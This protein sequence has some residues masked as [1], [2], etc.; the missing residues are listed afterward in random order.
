MFTMGSLQHFN[1]LTVFGNK[2][3]NGVIEQSINHG[4]VLNFEDKINSL[5]FG[6]VDKK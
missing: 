4:I 5:S 2:V 3:I 6:Y 1:T